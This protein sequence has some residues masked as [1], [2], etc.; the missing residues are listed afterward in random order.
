[1]RTRKKKIQV[2]SDNDRGTFLRVSKARAKEIF[3]EGTAKLYVMSSDRNPVE[4]LTAAHDYKMGCKPYYSLDMESVDSFNRLLCD[5]GEWLEYRG[6][7]HE[8]DP[9]RAAHEM[10]SYWVKIEN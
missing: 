1:M 10:F 8:P 9:Y 6:Y 5:F 3:E 4:W 2:I 7:G